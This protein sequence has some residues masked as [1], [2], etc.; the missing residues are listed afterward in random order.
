MKANT[1]LFGEIDIAEDKIITF[2]NGIIGFSQLKH[3]TLIYDEEKGVDAG[4]SFL[5]SMDEPS[6]AMPVMS[7]LLVQEDYNPSIEDELLAG[8]GDLNDDNM[9]VLVT[10]SVPS[11]LTKMTVNLQ[12]PFIINA[13]NN[14]A[15]QI[16]VDGE[17]YPVKFPIYDIIKNRKAGE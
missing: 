4:I 17:K 9:L 14:K 12:G 15:C 1:R 16:I 3:F 8:L 6:F 11:D 7:P 13:E 5:Q 10:V 2:E